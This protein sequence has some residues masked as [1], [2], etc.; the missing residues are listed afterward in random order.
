[1][2]PFKY[3]F[4]VVSK[5]VSGSRSAR[6]SPLLPEQGTTALPRDPVTVASWC[7]P[8]AAFA[9]TDEEVLNGGWL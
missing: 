8:F 6:G 7:I 3:T 2:N 1:M 5:I 9:C 4:C